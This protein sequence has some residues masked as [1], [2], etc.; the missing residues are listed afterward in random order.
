MTW[1]W[2][3]GPCVHCGRADSPWAQFPWGTANAC[4][5]CVKARG[6]ERVELPP[7]E[8]KSY[9]LIGKTVV[10]EEVT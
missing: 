8:L 5:S 1:H 4:D 9:R 10:I 7:V 6:G 3:N 2:R